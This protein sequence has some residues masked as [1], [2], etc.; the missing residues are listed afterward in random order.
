MNSL[1]LKKKKDVVHWRQ[2][3]TIIWICAKGLQKRIGI[4][5]MSQSACES[6]MPSLKTLFSQKSEFPVVQIQQSPSLCLELGPEFSS[7]GWYGILCF[8]EEGGLTEETDLGLLNLKGVH[9]EKS[10]LFV[11]GTRSLN[12]IIRYDKKPNSKVWKMSWVI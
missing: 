12:S 11:T 2:T 4:C 3:G 1:L 7:W 8:P 9:Q 10:V 6:A 5:S